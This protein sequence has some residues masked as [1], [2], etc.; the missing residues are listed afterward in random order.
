M[1][2]LIQADR[3]LEDWAAWRLTYEF[4]LGTGNS[5]CCRMLEG[6]VIQAGSKPLWTGVIASQLAA[7]NGRLEAGL[8]P[9]AIRVLLV[10]YGVTGTDQWKAGQVGV[11]DRTLRR[12]KDRARRVVTGTGHAPCSSQCHQSDKQ[13]VL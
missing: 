9:L 1:G 13:L 10:I 3:L 8:P 2:R 11:S 6:G 5:S 4:Y 7:V 12:L